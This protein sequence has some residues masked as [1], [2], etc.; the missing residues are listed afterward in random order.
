MGRSLSSDLLITS[1][2]RLSLSTVGGGPPLLR[3]AEERTVVTCPDR[4]NLDRRQLTC[5][6]ALHDGER[7]RLLNLQHNSIAR[8]G[9][10]L[11]RLTRL[12]F[13]DLYDNLVAEI[14]GLDELW[15]LRVLMLGKNRY[16]QRVLVI[17]TSCFTFSCVCFFG[18]VL[19]LCPK[20]IKRISGLERLV[21]L[22]V[23]DLHGNLVSTK[24]VCVLT[25]LCITTYTHITH[26]HI[27][28]HIHHGHTFHAIF[29][30]R[31]ERWIISLTSATFVSST[32]QA[33]N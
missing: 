20:R 8:L 17:S 5:C 28:I 25:Q 14:S 1:V 21:H 11:S 33:M 31:S 27:H 23:L 7:L 19:M 26:I 24:S 18:F 9:E 2:E 10:N 3:T 22:D 4:L 30:C 29:P 32:W 6:P 13:L 12:V 16:A 15:S